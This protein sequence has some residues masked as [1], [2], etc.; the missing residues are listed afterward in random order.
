[1]P[2]TPALSAAPHWG[3]QVG[4]GSNG[5]TRLFG[6]HRPSLCQ[7]ARV[8]LLVSLT[9]PLLRNTATSNFGE[10]LLVFDFVLPSAKRG[11]RNV[12]YLEL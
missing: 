1:M 10:C 5:R 11:L 3:Y 12:R 4:G 7:L 8:H 6:L 2:A 9:S